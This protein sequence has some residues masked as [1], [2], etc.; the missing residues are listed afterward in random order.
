MYQFDWTLN[1]LPLEAPFVEAAH[2]EAGTSPARIVDVKSPNSPNGE[3][4]EA[5]T[6]VLPEPLALLGGQ[7]PMWFLAA[8]GS[9]RADV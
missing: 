1:A 6:G 4:R 2:V 9:W 3:D 7:A 8:S 5:I